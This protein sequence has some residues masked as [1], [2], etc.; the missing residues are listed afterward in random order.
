MS[1]LS[2]HWT[3]RPLSRFRTRFPFSAE[4]SLCPGVLHRRSLVRSGGYLYGCPMIRRVLLWDVDG[5]L[6]KTGGLGAAVFDM[7]RWNVCSVFG[8]RFA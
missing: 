5:T 8:L 2:D 3:N 7:L 6:V 1:Q 4:T